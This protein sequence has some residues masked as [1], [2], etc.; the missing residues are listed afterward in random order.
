MMLQQKSEPAVTGNNSTH[1]ACIPMVLV[2]PNTI[3][4][5]TPC[6]KFMTL[7]DSG[8]EETW[9]DKRVLPLRCIPSKIPTIQGYKALYTSLCQAAT[10]ATDTALEAFEAL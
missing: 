6:H 3:N 2:V 4:K 1:S 7:L 5:I 10:R 9:I 8:L